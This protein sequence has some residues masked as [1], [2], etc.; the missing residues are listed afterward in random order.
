MRLGLLGLSPRIE[1]ADI[2]GFFARA[3]AIFNDPVKV[4]ASLETAP[5]G[6]GPGPAPQ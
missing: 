6:P 1:I 2:V 4:T 5:A 3:V